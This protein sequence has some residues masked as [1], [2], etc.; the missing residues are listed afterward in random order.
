MRDV[1]P[2]MFEIHFRCS[3]PKHV[4]IHRNQPSVGLIFGPSRRPVSRHEG[5]QIC[6]E[7]GIAN[8]E[9]RPPV[10]FMISIEMMDVF[11]DPKRS[12]DCLF[13]NYSMVFLYARVHLRSPSILFAMNHACFCQSALSVVGSRLSTAFSI[14]LVSRTSTFFIVFSF[15]QP[16]GLIMSGPRTGRGPGEYFGEETLRCLCA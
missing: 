5:M 14:I 16:E 15:V 4:A 11:I 6:M 13:S 8:K 3:V 12:T 7:R 10:V 1:F 2:G 9:I